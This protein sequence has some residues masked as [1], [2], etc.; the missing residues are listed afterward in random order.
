MQGKLVD[1][2]RQRHVEGGDEWYFC[3]LLRV[4]GTGSCHEHFRKAEAVKSEK[5]DLTSYNISRRQGR[6][7][8]RGRLKRERALG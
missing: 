3:T 7:R 8:E 5:Q 1:M 6:E 2:V 4:G